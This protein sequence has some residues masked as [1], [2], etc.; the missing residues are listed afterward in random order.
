MCDYIPLVYSAKDWLF[1]DCYRR[2]LN[3]KEAIKSRNVSSIYVNAFIVVRSMA[4]CYILSI[5]LEKIRLQ[6]FYTHC[7]VPGIRLLHRGDL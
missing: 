2:S 3:G 1:V 4:L 5:H 7:I 6:V